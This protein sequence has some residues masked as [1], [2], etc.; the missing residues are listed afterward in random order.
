MSKLFKTAGDAMDG[1][2]RDGLVV[3][4]GGFGYSQCWPEFY[5]TVW[6]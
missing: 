1:L 5:G 4:S 2:C 6:L 3:M